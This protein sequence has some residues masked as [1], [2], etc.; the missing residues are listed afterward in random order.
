MQRG[1]VVAT[2]AELPGMKLPYNTTMISRFFFPT[3]LPA[4][5]THPMPEALAHHAVRVLRLRDGDPVILFDGRGGERA[6]TL[7]VRGREVSVDLGEGSD[8]S[9]ESPLRAVLVQALASGDK[10]DWIVQKAVELGADAI[11]PLQAERSVLRLSGERADKRVEH[12][13]QVAVAACEQSGRNRVPELMRPC[14][15]REYL[16]G[17]APA[18]RLTLDPQAGGRL[19]EL[20]RP[21]GAVHV[22]IG[23]EGGWSDSELA[24]CRSAGCRGV[25]LGPRVLRTETAG[26]AAL[27]AMQA[28]WGDF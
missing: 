24:L 19:S 10:M 6:A 25:G 28:L 11:L 9:R 18:V 4:G 5:G 2:I 23:P 22:L 13:R 7:R 14:T 1:R 12:W 17:A 21:G 15:L 27:A 20:P 26:L 3:P 16:G 8:V